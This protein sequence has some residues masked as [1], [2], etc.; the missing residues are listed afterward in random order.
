MEQPTT[1]DI[2]EALNKIDE[3]MV[4]LVIKFIIG[5]VV[6]MILKVI[7]E[8]IVGYIMFRL[9]SHVCVGTPVDIYGKKGRIQGV[10]IFEIVVETDCGFIRVPSKSWRASKYIVLKDQLALRNRRSGDNITE[11]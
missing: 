11:C 7:A 9:D 2:L 1:G 3:Q 5:I 4:L 8:N 6:I 10:S